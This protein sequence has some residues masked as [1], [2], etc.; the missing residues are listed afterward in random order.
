MPPAGT[1]KCR[2]GGLATG[3]IDEALQPFG[4][5]RTIAT[6]VGGY[7]TALALARACELIAS[8]PE[9]HTEKLRAGMFSFSLPVQVPEFTVSLLWHPRLHADP[10]H[11][12]LRGCVRDVCAGQPAAPSAPASR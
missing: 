5:Q 12:W 3:P 8:G 7:A 1:S 2:G 4:L 6:I 10:A 9:R 11:R